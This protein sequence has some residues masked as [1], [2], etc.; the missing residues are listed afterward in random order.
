M[1]VSEELEVD[2]GDIVS[3]SFETFSRNSTP[4]KPFIFRVRIDLSWEDVIKSFA[5]EAAHQQFLNGTFFIA[6]YSSNH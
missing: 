3:F 5:D 2:E 4:V 1:N 6:S